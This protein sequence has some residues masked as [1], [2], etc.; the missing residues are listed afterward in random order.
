MGRML[1]LLVFFAVFLWS[2]VGPFDRFT[3]FL[4]VVPALIG[5]AILAATERRF[6]LTP[7][8]IGRAHV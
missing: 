1:W 3:W 8:E 2:A 5:F 7:L 4:E 6:P